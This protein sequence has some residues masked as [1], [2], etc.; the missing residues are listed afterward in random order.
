MT[1]TNGKEADI[2]L[3][4]TMSLRDWFAGLAMQ[5][6]VNNNP[7]AIE[8]DIAELAYRQA[9]AMIKKLEGDLPE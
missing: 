3:Q 2:H 7:E 8:K 4:A 1:D 9:D 6:L 5:T